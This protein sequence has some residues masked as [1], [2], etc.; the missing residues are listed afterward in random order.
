MKTAHIASSLFIGLSLVAATIVYGQVAAEPSQVVARIS[1]ANLT[2]NDLQ[3]DQGGKLLQAEYQ[4]YLSER[5]ALEELIDNRLLADEASRKAISLDQ[6]LEAEVYKGVKDPTE[7]QL[8][9]YYE[10]LDTQESF[11]SARED[12]LQHIRELRRTKA[13][14]AYVEQLRKQAS[15]NVLLMPPSAQVDVAKAY[16]LGAEK[17]PVVL[18]EFADYQC[19]YCQNVNAQI[20]KLKKEYGDSLSLVYKDFPLPMHAN[21]EKAA[22]A[23]RCAGEQGKYWEYHNLLFSSKQIEVDALKEHALALKLD[24]DRFN[25][26]LDSGAEAGA[27]KKDLEEAKSLGLT[28]TPSFFVNGHFFSGVVDYGTLKDMINQQLNVNAAQRP[29]V[30]MK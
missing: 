8:E 16:T 1:G 2:L 4:Y 6:L 17:A 29:Q 18:V 12:I 14:A 5:K 20:Q 28:G 25:T 26:C 23:A 3:Q 24:G 19:P 13:R 22:E 27:V 30:S 10:G 7:D 15:I 11:Q 21:A 9:V